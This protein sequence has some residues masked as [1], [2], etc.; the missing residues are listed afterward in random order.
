MP[1][2][3]LSASPGVFLSPGTVPDQTTCLLLK[4]LLHGTSRGPESP[5]GMV[6]IRTTAAGTH[7]WHPVLYNGPG[8]VRRTPPPLEL[9]YCLIADHSDRLLERQGGAVASLQ[10]EATD[11]I[12]PLQHGAIAKNTAWEIKM[13]KLFH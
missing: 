8:W 12:N 3:R 1:S 4:Q 9:G 7:P 10:R 11:S 13:G 2:P 5:L 6:R